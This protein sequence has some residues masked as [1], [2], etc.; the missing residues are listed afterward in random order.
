MMAGRVPYGE[1]YWQ[2]PLKQTAPL[3]P[4]AV[5]LGSV[6]CVQT[7]LGWVGVPTTL[8]P[9]A[10]H[11]LPSV[12]R[13]ATPE[14]QA[15]C[16]QT[17]FAE[18]GFVAAGQGVPSVTLAGTQPLS[19]THVEAVHGLPSS[20]FGGGPPTHTPRMQESPVVHRLPSS[21]EAPVG[22][23]TCWQPRMASQLSVVQEFLSSQ[24]RGGP[25]THWPL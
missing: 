23:A 16:T 15:P 24:S 7:A 20:Q 3:G 22:S 2:T 10:V 19:R 18:H 9:S 17:S 8:Q 5:K 11:G 21:H 4:Q 25:L 1:R 12:Q 6:P 13:V 14:V